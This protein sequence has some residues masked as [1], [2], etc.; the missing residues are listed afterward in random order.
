M[1]NLL[2]IEKPKPGIHTP[3][4]VSKTAQSATDLFKAYQKA[5]EKEKRE[6]MKVFLTLL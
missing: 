1:I 3:P 5:L 2:L 4:P 6:R